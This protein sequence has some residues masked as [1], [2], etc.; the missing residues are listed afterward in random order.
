MVNPL[1]RIEEWMEFALKGKKYNFFKAV[2]FPVCP[3]GGNP[4]LVRQKAKG[5]Q[6]RET[7][8]SY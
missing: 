1:T 2:Q 6:V 3:L 7:E 8:G 4:P 5:S